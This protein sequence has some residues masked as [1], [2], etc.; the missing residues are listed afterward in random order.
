MSAASIASGENGCS[1][2]G[3]TR[4]FRFNTL[5]KRQGLG[6]IPRSYFRYLKCTMGVLCENK[7]KK[8][9]VLFLG[10]EVGGRRA[11]A[12]VLPPTSVWLRCVGTKFV[13]LKF[14]TR[15][16]TLLLKI[17]KFENLNSKIQ[18]FKNLNLNFPPKAPAPAKFSRQNS[19]I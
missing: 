15:V 5:Y 2:V 10:F 18:K 14:S 7:K 1:A 16:C 17:F 3:R 13:Q 11:R 19:K 6:F 8:K 9:N 12:L 4:G